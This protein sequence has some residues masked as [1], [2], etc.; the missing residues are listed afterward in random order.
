MDSV[1]FIVAEG[2]ELEGVERLAE[3]TGLEPRVKTQVVDP[4]DPVGGQ[5][6]LFSPTDPRVRFDASVFGEGPVEVLVVETT[7]ILNVENL[8]GIVGQAKEA[9]VSIRFRVVDEE[10]RT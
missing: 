8:V 5:V 4:N 3:A 7:G 1:M 2:V 6:V 10:P 9:G